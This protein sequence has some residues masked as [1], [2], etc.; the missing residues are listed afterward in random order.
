MRKTRL[1]WLTMSV[2][3]LLMLSGCSYIR[4]LRAAKAPAAAD[5]QAAVQCAPGVWFCEDFEHG[6]ARWNLLPAGADPTVGTANGKAAIANEA[7]NHFLRY[8]AGQSRGVVALLKDEA[9]AGVRAR[10]TANYYVEARIRPVNN[11]TSNKFI[12]LLGRVQ[13]VNNWY[14]G[15]LN[16]QN[17]A[18]SKVEFHKANGG[19]WTRTRQFAT[20]SILNDQWYKLR[21]EMKGSSL[22]FYIDDDLAGSFSDPSLSAQGKI[23]LWL[24]N[25]SFDVDDIQVGDADS[26]PVLLSLDAD[27]NWHSEVGG[28]PLKVKVSATRADSTPDT[29]RVASDK[30]AVVS[31]RQADGEAVLQAE[32]AGEAVVTFASGSN[33]H[34]T[35]QIRVSVEPAF[36]ASGVAYGKLA[37][38][39]EPAA[40][41]RAA[42]ADGELGLSFD[43]APVLSGVGS[44]RIFRSRDDA[45]VDV[46]RPSG[47]SNVFGPSA[48]GFY[49][50]VN[51]PLIRVDGKRLVVR[52]HSGK[53]AWGES[54]Y[55]TLSDNL[56][57][58]AQLSGKP[59]AGLGKA[60]GWK[61]RLKA[62][63]PKKFSSLTVD[64]NGNKADFRSVQGALAHVMKYAGKDAPVT[65][66]VKNGTYEELLFLRGK[67]NLTIRGE[68]RNATLIRFNN[69]ESLN[70]GL[71]AGQQDAQAGRGGRAVFVAAN[72]DML[73]LER[74]TLQNTHVKQRGVSG[75]AET[76]YFAAD[77]ER[78][79]AKNASFLSR[80]DTLQLNGYSWF[81]DTLV[82]GDVDFIWGSSKAALFENS[83]IR[84]VVDSTDDTK[85][86]YLVQARVNAGE[87]KGYVFLNSR[88][89][90]EAGVPDGVTM[91]ARSA[92]SPRY[93]DNVVFVNS[94]M[95]K[96]IAPEGWLARPQPNPAKAD[97][98]A[99]WREYASRTMAGG[100]V[101]VGERLAA[102]HHLSAAE[103]APYT[104]REAVFSA[105]GWAPKP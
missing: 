12:C 21:M 91:L 17:S 22:N 55:V 1:A 103:A 30:P 95:D 10:R 25:R 51:M 98:K 13:D 97:A 45:L 40:G 46:I 81:Y 90:R 86:G 36:K 79:V 26:K 4:G 61:F 77:Q 3:G 63:P 54:Y 67:N 101:N 39:T 16:V 53:L 34:K 69:Y 80:Q 29:W 83:E 7:G 6:T 24:D 104:T 14:G 5:A 8:E 27:D 74:L 32:G 42:Y 65:I 71:S 76:I 33:P 105:I 9:F 85:G 47:E 18:S 82:A 66:N 56:L 2:A 70:T 31:V 73:T 96:H 50:G 48:D 100:P 94:R 38:L 78:L 20:R 57:D 62:E 99:G 59:F 58:G 93:F 68:S 35:R 88:L 23:G 84:T 72:A 28:E 52:P 44:V 11:Q 15:C 41:S 87:D 60:S 43:R 89:T 37:A 75:Q 92:G 102:A 49:R 64:D 19:K